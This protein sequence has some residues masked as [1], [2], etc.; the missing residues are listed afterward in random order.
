[1]VSLI[2]HF[3]TNMHSISRLHRSCTPLLVYMDEIR[4]MVAKNRLLTRHNDSSFQVTNVF[5]LCAL[6]FRPNE[7]MGTPDSNL[8][9]SLPLH[10]SCEGFVLRGYA[11]L[12]RWGPV[13]HA[14]CER[15]RGARCVYH[16]ISRQRF[17]GWGCG[18][19]SLTPENSSKRMHLVCMKYVCGDLCHAYDL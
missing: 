6:C 3:T 14:S 8:S 1:M 12:W 19:L 7:Y 2:A 9:H 16:R 4:Q 5:A 13:R 18:M 10:I 11:G 15:A 17:R